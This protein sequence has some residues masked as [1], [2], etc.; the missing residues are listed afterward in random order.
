VLVWGQEDVQGA[1]GSV[2]ASVVWVAG[3][4]D[5]CFVKHG[6]EGQTMTFAGGLLNMTDSPLSVLSRLAKHNLECPSSKFGSVLES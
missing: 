2:S 3:E 4:F 1:E 5:Y 6:F